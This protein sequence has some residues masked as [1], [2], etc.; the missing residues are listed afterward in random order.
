MEGDANSIPPC[1][2]KFSSDNV[3]TYCY[4][5]IIYKQLKLYN[6]QDDEKDL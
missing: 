5:S 4:V 3:S 6:Y 2:L 1:F